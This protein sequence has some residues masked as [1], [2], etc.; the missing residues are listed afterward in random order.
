VKHQQKYLYKRNYYTKHDSCK[1][2]QTVSTW[3]R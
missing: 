1:F 2:G 3:Y